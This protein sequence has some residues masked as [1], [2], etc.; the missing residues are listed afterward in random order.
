MTKT[1]DKVCAGA[2]GKVRLTLK[3]LPEDKSYV[4][5]EGDKQAF[6]FLRDLFAAHA[7]DDDCGFQIA[8]HGPGNALFKKGSNFGLY[9]HR[10]PC[11]EK[12]RTK[13]K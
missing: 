10:L 4:L 12:K 8:P 3:A 11:T 2:A 5:I 7:V 6:E 9:L 13:Q 1:P